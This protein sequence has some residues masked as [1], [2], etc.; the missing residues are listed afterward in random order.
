MN[1][2]KDLQYSSRTVTHIQR[3]RQIHRLRHIVA[4]VAARL[5]EPERVR[6]DVRIM[7]DY[8]CLTRMHVVRLPAPRIDGE[9]YNKD[10][11]FSASGIRIRREAGYVDTH[12]TLEQKPWE[13]D[14]DP[15][16]GFVLHEVQHVVADSATQSRA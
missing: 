11:D 1:R 14:Y 5:P 3:Q 4:E 13:S 9:D 15:L 10:I 12:R 2:Q 8:G 6:P 7:A 16:D